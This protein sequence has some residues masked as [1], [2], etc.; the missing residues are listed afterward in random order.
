MARIVVSLLALLGLSACSFQSDLSYTP[1]KG[2]QA[3]APTAMVTVSVISRS[4]RLG[5]TRSAKII[6][7]VSGR[8]KQRM[9]VSSQSST[10]RRMIGRARRRTG[11]M[12]VPPCSS[13][14]GLP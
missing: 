14:E 12:P 4:L 2:Q 1:L 10:T 8:Y 3:E 13:A 6:C 5:P 11:T 9:Q 7:A